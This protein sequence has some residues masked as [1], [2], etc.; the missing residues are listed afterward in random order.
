MNIGF[1]FKRQAKKWLAN[2]KASVQGNAQPTMTYSNLNRT[3]STNLLE[4]KDRNWLIRMITFSNFRFF[5]FPIELWVKKQTLLRTWA[6]LIQCLTYNK[7]SIN[8]NVL[9]RNTWS[10]FSVLKPPQG[11]S[12][13]LKMITYYI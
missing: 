13:Y 1:S 5:F 6:F 12:Y 7:G 2:Y 4:S 8:G 11:H 9:F 3:Q 10:E